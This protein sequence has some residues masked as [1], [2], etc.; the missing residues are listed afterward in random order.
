MATTRPYQPCH[1]ECFN[2]VGVEKHRG[3]NLAEVSAGVFN[4]RIFEETEPRPEGCANENLLFMSGGGKS[5]GNA[6]TLASRKTDE[7]SLQ[8][9]RRRGPPR[10]AK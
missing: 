8:L 4:F 3:L 7:G 6:A 9:F 10:S 5:S 1:S 2:V